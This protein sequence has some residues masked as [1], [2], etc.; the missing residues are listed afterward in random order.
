MTRGKLQVS[1]ASG[2]HLRVTYKAD[3]AI[4]RNHLS[5]IMPLQFRTDAAS[6]VALPKQNIMMGRTR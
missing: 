4:P 2:S 6:S 3:S 5:A 1:F